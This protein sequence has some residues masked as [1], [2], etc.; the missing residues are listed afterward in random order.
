MGGEPVSACCT[1]AGRM[2]IRHM[3][4]PL[5]L[6]VKGGGLRLAGRRLRVDVAVTREEAQQLRAK[7]VKK[8]TGTRNL[9]LAREG[10]E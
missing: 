9:Y 7:K 6:H 10:C 8:P 2:E 3:V 1:P 5:P 4:S